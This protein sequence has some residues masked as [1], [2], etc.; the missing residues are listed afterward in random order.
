MHTAAQFL[1]TKAAYELRGHLINSWALVIHF[2]TTALSYCNSGEFWQSFNWSQT[3]HRQIGLCQCG[4]VVAEGCR[5]H[6][7]VY[8]R[9]IITQNSGVTSR[10][11]VSGGTQYTITKTSK[12][13]ASWAPTLC[14]MAILRHWF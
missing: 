9:A 12:S 11:L 4:L 14:Y 3:V 5:C 8:S 7:M 2:F 10:D 6:G 1:S 13:L